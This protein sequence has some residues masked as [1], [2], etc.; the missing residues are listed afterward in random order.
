MSAVVASPS[1][2][3]HCSLPLPEPSAPQRDRYPQMH[4]QV[5]LEHGARRKAYRKDDLQNLSGTELIDILRR[6][7]GWASPSRPCQELWDAFIRARFQGDA[8]NAAGA[9]LTM[10]TWAGLL[11]N[12]T[13]IFIEPETARPS[14]EPAALPQE[15]LR[16]HRAEADKIQHEDKIIQ[17]SALGGTKGKV[18]AM[19]RGLFIHLLVLI[20]ALGA[21]FVYVAARRGY[22]EM[23]EVAVLEQRIPMCRFPIPL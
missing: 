7:L 14:G 18:C 1:K 9:S 8:D 4:A 5:I 21:L 6:D 12:I 22:C 15:G 16:A 10:N 13:V 17:T 11:H 20:F 3:P 2:C 23:V 19:L